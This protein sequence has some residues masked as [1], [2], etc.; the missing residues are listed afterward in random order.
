VTT[1]ADAEEAV[2]QY[3]AGTLQDHTEKLH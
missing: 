2:N 1:V 3:I